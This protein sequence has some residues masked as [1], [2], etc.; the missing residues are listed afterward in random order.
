MAQRGYCATALTL[1]VFRV[2]GRPNAITAVR[3]MATTNIKKLLELRQCAV[4]VGSIETRFCR[5]YSRLA[6]HDP[7]KV[8][9]LTSIVDSPTD[10]L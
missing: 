3:S 10:I 5:V 4:S 6:L 2:E 8:S 7:H 9:Y 1:R